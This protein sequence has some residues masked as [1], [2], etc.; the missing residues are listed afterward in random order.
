M[1]AFVLTFVI[2]AVI[3]VALRRL[4]ISVADT[5]V[6]RTLNATESA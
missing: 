4:I 2:A 6:L 5:V 3:V 1:V